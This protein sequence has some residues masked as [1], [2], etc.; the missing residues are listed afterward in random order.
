MRKRVA[1]GGFCVG[2]TRQGAHAMHREARKVAL[3]TRSGA[4][5]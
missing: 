4:C 1:V 2:Q 3:G 5:A